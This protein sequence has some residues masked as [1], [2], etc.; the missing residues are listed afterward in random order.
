MI[1]ALTFLEKSMVYTG[2]DPI[3]KH[4]IEELCRLG[5]KNAYLKQL[6]EEGIE[7][8]RCAVCG[9]K[10]EGLSVQRMTRP[11]VWHN[12]NCFQWKPRKIIKLERDFGA[13]IVDILKESTRKCGKIKVQ[14][15][16]LGISIPYLYHI[17]R[18][19]C[20]KDIV[21]FMAENSSGK[22]RELYAKKVKKRATKK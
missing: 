4:I 5:S 19:Y 15:D 6:I 3:E 9:E 20:D 1:R 17:I 14:C 11:I 7:N 12:R 22:R 8:A 10:L 2:N 13:D 16:F 21:R 18:K